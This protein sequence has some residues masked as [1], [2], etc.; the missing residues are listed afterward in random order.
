MTTSYV[1]LAI[2]TSGHTGTALDP[3]SWF[4]MKEAIEDF[5]VDTFYIKG[6]RTV[7]AWPDFIGDSPVLFSFYA[8]DPLVNGTF[9]INVT[10]S[11]FL[12]CLMGTWKQCV[13]NFSSNIFIGGLFYG[14]QKA[15]YLYTVNLYVN[16]EILLNSSENTFKG[17]T[18]RTPDK[19]SAITTDTLF[20]DTLIDTLDWY[21]YYGQPTIVMVNSSVNTLKLDITEAGFSV[22]DSNCQYLWVPPVWPAW[23]ANKEEWSY[24]LLGTEITT[25]PN[26]GVVPYTDYE[27]GLFGEPRLG[28]GALYFDPITPIEVSYTNSLSL[29]IITPQVKISG[30]M[31]CIGW[32]K[33][34]VVANGDVLIPLAVSDPEGNVLNTDS[35]LKFEIKRIGSD[36]I[37]Q[38]SGSKSK[39]IDKNLKIK[40]DDNNWHMLSFEA[41]EDGNMSYSVD[42]VSLQP[43]DGL[44]T[45]GLPYSV[46]KS[47]TSRVGGGK[48]RA[49]YIYKTEQIVYL[50]NWR[51]GKDF[52]LGLK[53]I[54]ELMA[55]DK[56]FLKIP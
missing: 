24:R 49:P 25:P 32:V 41:D 40:I 6:E 44:D 37:L 30:M 2:N 52:N 48:V 21:V 12:D 35:S 56:E 8:W 53:W 42:G 22:I 51:F 26:P 14:R 33:G 20:Q 31:T 3:F 4:D 15:A 16:D 19:I 43:E 10:K 23:F 27:T 38:Y 11:G 28:I 29:N 50:Y 46:A 45:Y 34:P 47:L 5:S 7:D 55:I 17:C 39:P 9:R 18:V 36:Y 54:N 1:D 13:L